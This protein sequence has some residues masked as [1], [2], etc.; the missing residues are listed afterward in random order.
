MEDA[1]S[2][3]S[4]LPKGTLRSDIKE[5]LGLYEKLR[6]ERA[7]KIQEF[8]R[9]AG[10]DLTKEN[11]ES[12]NSEL[13]EVHWHSVHSLPNLANSHGICQLQLWAR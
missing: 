1:A 10:T 12:F 5:R 3:I 6:D 8:T 2:L 13:L 9:Q 11:R 7:H 4:L